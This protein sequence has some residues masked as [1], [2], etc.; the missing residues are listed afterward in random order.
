[1]LDLGSGGSENSG[2]ERGGTGVGLSSGTGV[3]VGVSRLR[4]TWVSVGREEVSVEI[5]RSRLGEGTEVPFDWHPDRRITVINR[6]RIFS[7]EVPFLD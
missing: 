3:N 1:M 2:V 5:G 6:M 7:A 4:L